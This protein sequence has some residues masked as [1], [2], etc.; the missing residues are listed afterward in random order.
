M[1]SKVSKVL[2]VKS[3][4]NTLDQFCKIVAVLRYVFDKYF[5]NTD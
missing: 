5:E 2:D 1:V 4:W 3:Y